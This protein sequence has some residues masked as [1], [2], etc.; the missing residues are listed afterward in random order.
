MEHVIVHEKAWVPGTRSIEVKFA[1]FVQKMQKIIKNH[2]LKETIWLLLL[3][4]HLF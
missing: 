2:F 4:S 3:K 1:R